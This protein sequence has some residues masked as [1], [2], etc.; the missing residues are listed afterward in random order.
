MNYI[1]YMDQGGL[2]SYPY[3]SK[4]VLQT[5]IL[6]LLGIKLKYPPVLYGTNFRKMANDAVQAKNMDA[7][8]PTR[9]TSATQSNVQPNVSGTGV[10]PKFSYIQP[11]PKLASV[12]DDGLYSFVDHKSRT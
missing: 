3:Y 7:K 9:A 5:P 2:T 11:I 10:I 1:E 4:R 8:N 12:T 6:D